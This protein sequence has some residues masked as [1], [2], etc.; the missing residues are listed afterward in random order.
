MLAMH[1]PLESAP[2]VVCTP[3]EHAAIKASPARWDAL[4]L[5]GYTTAPDGRR[6]EQRQCRCRSTLAKWRAGGVA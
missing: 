3:A 4:P 2:V 1:A 5:L 6:L